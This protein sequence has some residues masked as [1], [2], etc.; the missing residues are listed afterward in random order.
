V[1]VKYFCTFKS[2]VATLTLIRAQE[3]I[4]R[5]WGHK[6]IFNFERNIYHPEY[7]IFQG[8]VIRA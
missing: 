7:A 5:T 3:L 1:Q 2:D 6:T 8:G 4:R